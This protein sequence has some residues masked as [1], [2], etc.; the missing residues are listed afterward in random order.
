MSSKERERIEIASL[1]C[2]YQQQAA[3]FV[4]ADNPSGLT[5]KFI[6]DCKTHPIRMAIESDF[7]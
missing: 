3:L 5:Y 4:A 2:C 6:D 1:R 7:N